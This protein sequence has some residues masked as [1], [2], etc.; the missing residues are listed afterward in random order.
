MT[1]A[2]YPYRSE[3]LEIYQ[4]TQRFRETARQLSEL[5]PELPGWNWLRELVSKEIKMILEDQ[6][7]DSDDDEA[8]SCPEDELRRFVQKERD[9]NR[10]INNQTRKKDRRLNSID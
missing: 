2:L 3:I 10:I 5:H 8:E 9:F 6:L 1:S 7:D 4:N